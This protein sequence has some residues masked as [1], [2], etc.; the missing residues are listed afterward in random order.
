MTFTEFI[1]V[2]LAIGAPFGVHYFLK[3]GGKRLNLALFFK[4]IGAT[5]CWFLFAASFV[6]SRLISPEHTLLG[7]NSDFLHYSEIKIVSQNLQKAFA[8]FSSNDQTLSF[9]EFREMLERFIGLTLALQDSSVTAVVPE[10]EL[11]I[12]HIAGYQKGDLQLAGKILH[13]KNYLR[14]QSHQLFARHEFLQLCQSLKEKTFVEINDKL[15]VWQQYQSEAMRL[16][17]L[18]GDSEAFQVFRKQRETLLLVQ[19]PIFGTSGKQEQDLWKI[20]QPSASIKTFPIAAST[21]VMTT[22]IPD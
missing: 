11:E 9:F 15:D 16:S 19:P 1:T 7:E 8:N 13:R 22:R 6:K 12:F 3:Q 20:L 14:L 17:E 18:L 21:P 4:S 5:L 10:H 2:Y